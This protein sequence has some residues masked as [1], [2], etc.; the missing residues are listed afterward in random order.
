MW[1]MKAQLSLTLLLIAAAVVPGVT[2]A[3][4]TQPIPGQ[5]LPSYA[6]PISDQ[7]IKGRIREI[8]NP[9][10]I[11]VL[12]DRGYLDSVQLHRGTII[13]PT[14]LTLAVGMRVTILGYNSGDVF[15]ANEIDTPYTYAQLPP[16]VFYGPGWWYPGYVYGWGPRFGL[17]IN[18]GGWIYR[19]P[20]P[21][22]RPYVN[23][24]YPRPYI[25]HPYVGRPQ[26]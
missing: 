20:F 19:G 25:G 16:P 21:H 17:F 13:N 26:H 12:D 2:A 14:G 18:S 5:T 22:S 24:P 3:A 10:N 7:T 1:K 11:K 9:F 15:D 6:Q 4:Q 8:N 23:P